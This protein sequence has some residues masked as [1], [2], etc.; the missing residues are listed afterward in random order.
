MTED[1]VTGFEQTFRT[2]RLATLDS[3]WCL[4]LSKSLEEGVSVAAGDRY[5]SVFGPLLRDQMTLPSMDLMKVVMD[6][7]CAPSSLTRVILCPVCCRGN[8]A[9]QV[10]CLHCL[11]EWKQTRLTE[12]CHHTRCWGKKKENEVFSRRRIRAYENAICYHYR[13]M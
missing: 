8:G 3:L 6:W 13:E 7:S 5:I 11:K 9:S 4:L 2:K 12:D 1:T 10:F